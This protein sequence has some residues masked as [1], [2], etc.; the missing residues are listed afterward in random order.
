MKN[1]YVVKVIKAL[2][3]IRTKETTTAPKMYE[4]TFAVNLKTNRIWYRGLEGKT[5]ITEDTGWVTVKAS[6]RE[7]AMEEAEF[8]AYLK[9]K[10]YDSIGRLIGNRK[11]VK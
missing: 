8:Q 10:N 6:T 11:E 3:G 2:L 4:Y 9:Y 7:R 1:M 5:I